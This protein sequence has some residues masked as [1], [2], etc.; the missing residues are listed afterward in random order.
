MISERSRSAQRIGVEHALNLPIGHER[1]VPGLFGH[2]DRH[3]V[4]F[5]GQAERGAMPR[6]ELLAQPRIDGQRQE[7]GSGR[8]AIALHDHGAVVERR[9]RLK[10]TEQQVV[11]HDRVERNPALDVVAQPDLPFDG[12]DGANPLA[13]QHAGR[14]HEFLDR[15]LRR[16]LLRE[17]AEERRP[18]EVGERAA[19]VGLEQDDEREHEVTRHVADQPVDRFEVPP[20]RQEE[21]ADEDRRPERHLDGARAAN[22]LQDLVNQHR[23]HEDVEEVPPIGGRTA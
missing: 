17:V 19:D 8:H 3:R 11:R 15:L 6:T 10:D 12:D 4:V 14:H 20:D 13:R 7:A 16:L 5:L 22:Q 23:H 1:D 9:R 2:H 21:Q 18:P